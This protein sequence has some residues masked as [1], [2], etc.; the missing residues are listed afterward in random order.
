MAAL[1]RLTAADYDSVLA[2]WQRAGLPSLRPD[3]RDSRA[4]FARQLSAGQVVLGLEESGRLIA[5]VVV[6]HDARKGWINRLAVEPDQRR[7]GH[8]LRLVRAAEDALREQ[9]LAVYAALIEDWN[10]ASLALFQ[11][12]GYAVHRDILYVSK[13]DSDRA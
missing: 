1:R 2:V 5:C 13:R 3:G 9:G 6:T 8:G 4:A 10:D 12:A 7:Q 11:K